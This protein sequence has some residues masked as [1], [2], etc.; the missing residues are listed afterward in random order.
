MRRA[1]NTL[2][3]PELQLGLQPTRPAGPNLSAT[4][5]RPRSLL[6]TGENLNRGTSIVIQQPQ[7][8]PWGPQRVKKRWFRHCSWQAIPPFALW[9]ANDHTVTS[10]PSYSYWTQ[11]AASTLTS[12]PSSPA[13]QLQSS[14]WPQL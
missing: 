3:H 5:D 11:A 13:E 12:N 9:F 14:S 4:A 6:R 2:E 1:H 10:P 8:R 7:L